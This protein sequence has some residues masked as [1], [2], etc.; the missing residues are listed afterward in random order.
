MIGK[1]LQKKYKCRLIAAVPEWN[2]EIGMNV[3]KSFKFDEYVHLEQ[4]F[5]F[6]SKINLS[7]S[8]EAKTIAEKRKKLLNFSIDGMKIGDIAYDTYLRTE[9]KSSI[10][11]IDQKVIDH[12]AATIRFWKFYDSLVKCKNVLG[13]VLSHTYYTEYAPLACSILANGGV[14]FSHHGNC[15]R[16]YDKLDE[17]GDNIYTISKSEFDIVYQNYQ[18]EA[19]RCAEKYLDTEVITINKKILAMLLMLM[20]R[21]KNF[22]PEK[23][24]TMSQNSIRTSLP[25]ASCPMFFPML[26][27]QSVLWSMSIITSGLSRP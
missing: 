11:A 1:I 6:D 14:V 27:I 15:L 21:R 24:S 4:K 5:I 2:M 23:N 19:I 17:L 8:L 7:S 9:K 3:A 22:T 10:F 12:L 18:K 26:S 25:L 16:C 20:D 13:G